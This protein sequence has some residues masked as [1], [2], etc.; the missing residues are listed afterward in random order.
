MTDPSERPTVVFSKVPRTPD[1][2][3]EEMVARGVTVSQHGLME[4][5]GAADREAQAAYARG[6][7]REPMGAQ[8]RVYPEDY[9]KMSGFR[10]EI[11]VMPRDVVVDPTGWETLQRLFEERDRFGW[12]R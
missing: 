6:E 5:W 2:T 11:L 9:K 7:H 3:A 4:L 10:V 1:L 8:L 12:D